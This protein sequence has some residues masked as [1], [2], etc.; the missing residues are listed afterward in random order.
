MTD[1]GDR[2]ER[3]N[4]AAWE[5]YAPTGGGG[6]SGTPDPHHATHE[7]GGSDPLV[8]A[9]WTD[10]ANIFADDQTVDG[11]LFVTGTVNPLT[12]EQRDQIN[13]LIGEEGGAR[14]LM[15]SSFV[16]GLSLRHDEAVARGRIACGNYDT[17][18]YQPLAFEVEALEVHTGVSPASRV[19]HVRVHPLGGVTVGEGADHATDPGVGIIIARGLDGTPLDATSLLSGT[20]PDARLSANVLQHPGGYPG[21]SATFLRADAT[22]AAPPTG[23]GGG[24]PD[25]H[26]ATHEPGGSDVLQVSAATRVLGRGSA[27]AG[28]LQELT[29]GD[30]LQMTGTVLSSPGSRNSALVNYTYNSTLTE[31]PA[32]GQVRFNGAHPFTAVTKLW[33]RTTSADGQDVYWGLMV[34]SPG[35]V[36]LVQDK[37]DHT[38]YVRFTTTALPIDKG[39]YAEIAVAWKENSVAP[40]VT[41][42]AVLMQSTAV[43]TRIHHTTHE[44]GGSDP[45][46]VDAA[47]A[48][49]SLRTLGTGATQA[50]P[51]NDAR[52]SNAR[53]PTAHKTTH[54]PGGSDA[55]TALSASILTT[56]T[57][58]DAR[59]SANV[60][61][62]DQANTFLF[63]QTISRSIPRLQLIETDQPANKRHFEIAVENQVVIFQCLDD[64]STVAEGAFSLSRTGHVLVTGD[65][66]EKNRL[67]PLGHWIDVPL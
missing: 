57:L 47:A 48:V 50:A 53:T 32:A 39:L 37:D 45:I 55:L 54:E 38:K 56:G 66:S 10:V 60:A 40:L 29:L 15:S 17:Q 63:D 24:A 12:T 27:S 25:P 64:A 43:T 26:H 49:G 65:V 20:V 7:P 18:S 1:E 11:D 2:V 36:I 23:G 67:V 6:G 22:F 31:P 58:P 5:L 42:Q 4:G 35:S 21:G 8:N 33:M 19:E 52:L 62:R 9:A 44:P 46:A 16:S 51:G 28:P 59:L 14:T 3:S 13:A 30:G 41:A 34:V 61:R